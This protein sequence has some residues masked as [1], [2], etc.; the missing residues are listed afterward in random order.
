MSTDSLTLMGLFLTPGPGDHLVPSQ[1]PS[2]KTNESKG[3]K[4]LIQITKAVRERERKR[5]GEDMFKAQNK[6]RS[7]SSF[8]LQLI[9]LTISYLA[10]RDRDTR[11]KKREK[12]EKKR[13][14]KREKKKE[15]I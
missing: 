1:K 14:E 2:I 7:T 13:E 12:K 11:E 10:E 5:K 8:N 3:V 9:L 6:L 15:K 4:K